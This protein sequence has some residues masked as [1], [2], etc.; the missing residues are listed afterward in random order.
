ME[1]WA[2]D[3]PRAAAAWLSALPAGPTR[4]AAAGQFVTSI[5]EQEPQLAWSWAVTL[6]DAQKQKEAMETAGRQWLR[7]DDSAARAAIQSSGLPAELIAGLLKHK[8]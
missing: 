3:D 2:K 6:S 4:E 5:A 7:V 1:H 8:E